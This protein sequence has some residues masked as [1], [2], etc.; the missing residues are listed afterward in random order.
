[1]A[2][3]IEQVDKPAM[4][5]RP[6]R[7]F[8]LLGVALLISGILFL[9][10][11][12]LKSQPKPP[13]GPNEGAKTFTDSSAPAGARPD[14]GKR[15]AD[16]TSGHKTPQVSIDELSR[17]D[18]QANA[19]DAVAASTLAS[20]SNHCT[21]I[22]ATTNVMNAFLGQDVGAMSEDQR[23]NYDRDLQRVSD[24]FEQYSDMC[25]RAGHR[26]V[27]ER[28]KILLRASELGDR[29]A[30]YCFANQAIDMTGRGLDADTIG[31]YREYAIQ[32]LDN[33]VAQGDWTAVRLLLN[34]Y[35]PPE[36]FRKD[37]AA[38]LVPANSAKAYAYAILLQLGQAL[39]V[40][41]SPISE[42]YLAEL[43]REM[44]AAEVASANEWANQIFAKSFAA[45]PKYVSTPECK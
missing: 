33:G 12:S 41:S 29:D 14:E 22:Q 20:Y 11:S 42:A 25:L 38:A 43:S 19:G 5:S 36:Y 8:I 26:L 45:Q 39:D 27:D 18:Q 17:L 21:A 30:G 32:V 13:L 34:A 15:N 16:H 10:L 1:M 4:R 6:F 24:L 35:H 28:P 37:F 7:A 44:S 31:R 9:D 2:E 40:E 3:L 23:T